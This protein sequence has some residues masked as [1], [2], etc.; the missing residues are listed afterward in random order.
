MDKSAPRLSL[1]ETAKSIYQKEGLWAF[2]QSLP[3]N[4]FRNSII[5]AAELATYSQFKSFF[6]STGLFKNENFGLYFVCSF[7]AGWMAVSIGSPFDVIKSRMMVGKMVN[8]QN[9]LYSGIPEA[10]S[11]LFQEKG[12]KGFYGGYLINCSRL[13]SWNVA[14]F[15]T[16]EKLTS[17]YFNRK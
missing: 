9:V 5:N 15:L 8:G 4:I 7:L 6:L 14:M 3:P 2:Y 16:K 11:H 13:I 1:I 10:V 12:I 17:I